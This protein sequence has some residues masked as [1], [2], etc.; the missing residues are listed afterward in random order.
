[1][2]IIRV[3]SEV[4]VAQGRKDPSQSFGFQKCGLQMGPGMFQMFDRMFSPTRNEKPL[5]EG[6]YKVEPE[7]PYLDRNGNLHYGYTLVPVA[8]SKV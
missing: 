6:D 5:P 8:A 4:R 2:N 3:T 7:K 1:M